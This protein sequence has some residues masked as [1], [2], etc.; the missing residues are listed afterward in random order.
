[1]IFTRGY[2]WGS[3]AERNAFGRLKANTRMVVKR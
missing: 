3:K 2:S 1:M